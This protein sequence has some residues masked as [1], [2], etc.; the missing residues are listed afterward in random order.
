MDERVKKK[1]SMA[2]LLLITQEKR[3]GIY[4][5]DKS[6]LMSEKSLDPFLSIQGK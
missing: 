2:D 3:S 4:V 5:G 6:N 1:K